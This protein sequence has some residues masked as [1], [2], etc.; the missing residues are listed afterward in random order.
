LL[1]VSIAGFSQTTTFYFD[2]DM[3]I[4][5]APGA[6]FR[7]TGEPD[8]SLYK[9]SCYNKENNQLLFMAHFTD[10]TFNLFQGLFR[11]FYENGV[12]ENEGVYQQG[13]ENGLWK[14]KDR[15]GNTL[16][17]IWYV[18]GT[19][20]M[21]T[22]YAYYQDQHL[23]SVT[24]NDSAHNLYHLIFYD[25]S[26]K[27]IENDS[28]SEDSDKIFTNVEIQA[29]FPGGTAAWTRYITREIEKDVD[30]FTKSDYGTCLVKFI[31]NTDGHISAVHAMNM[32]GTRLAK[33]AVKAIISGPNWSPAQLNGSYVKAYRIQ[34]I[35]LQNPN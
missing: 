7:G 17:S 24:T 30:N 25:E 4:V 22:T 33:I 10:S 11:S 6:L 16:D 26:G 31:V 12:I 5:S 27:I 28:S 18:N 8:N 15:H 9:L 23:E 34:P 2:K 19:K 29:A 21:S 32:A 20:E 14:K 13:K 3:N 35:T 1:F